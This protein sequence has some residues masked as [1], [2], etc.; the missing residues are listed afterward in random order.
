MAV[1]CTTLVIAH[2]LTTIRNA[3]KIVVIEKGRIIEEGN[4][5]ELIEK[6]GK[7]WEMNKKREPNQIH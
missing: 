7:Y 5:K 6:H 1:E 4:H 2:R 3:D